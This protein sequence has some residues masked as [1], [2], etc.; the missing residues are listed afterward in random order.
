MKTLYERGPHH[1]KL[2]TSTPFAEFF[3]AYHK[4]STQARGRTR[5]PIIT[6]TLPNYLDK[7]RSIPQPAYPRDSILLYV[8]IMVLR[9]LVSKRQEVLALRDLH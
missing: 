9:A 5:F 2:S 7:K 1:K 3:H 8:L 4:Y 6:F